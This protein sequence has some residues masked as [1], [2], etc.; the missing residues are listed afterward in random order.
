MHRLLHGRIV[1]TVLLALERKL[2]EK[3]RFDDIVSKNAEM[4]RIFALLP[5]ATEIWEMDADSVVLAA[6]RAEMVERYDAVCGNKTRNKQDVE[7]LVE[8]GVVPV[9][10]TSPHFVGSEVG[11]EQLERVY[12]EYFRRVQRAYDAEGAL[13]VPASWE[14]T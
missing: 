3:Y 12:E 4:E 14:E 5:L 7:L 1:E 6:V 13:P 9:V 2:D 8:R 11:Q 10:L